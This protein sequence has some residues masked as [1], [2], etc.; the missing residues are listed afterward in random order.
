MSKEEESGREV[1]R[2]VKE[3]RTKCDEDGL[4]S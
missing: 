3:L 4:G 2:R 1:E